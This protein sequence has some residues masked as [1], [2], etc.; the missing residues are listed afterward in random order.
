MGVPS[1]ATV[2]AGA[3]ADPDV[4]PHAPA[5]R[6]SAVSAAAAIVTATRRVRCGPTVMQSPSE[7]EI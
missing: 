5:S 2:S 1:L 3:P 7:L 6:A 4:L